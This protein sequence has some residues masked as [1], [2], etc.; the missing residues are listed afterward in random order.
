[1]KCVP[2]RTEARHFYYVS[3]DIG[4]SDGVIVCLSQSNRLKPR[5]M[6]LVTRRH[7]SNYLSDIK[8]MHF[9]AVL[10]IAVL[11]LIVTSAEDRP[12]STPLQFSNECP[13][14]L[15]VF[16]C[17]PI[18]NTTTAANITIDLKALDEIINEP[19]KSQYLNPAAPFAHV[20]VGDIRYVGVSGDSVSAG[21]FA[22]DTF[23]TVFQ[24]FRHYEH[25]E[26][27]WTTGTEEGMISLYNVFQRL[28][29]HQVQ[30]G[31]EKS[32]FRFFDKVDKKVGL[33]VAASKA[34]SEAL[35]DQLGRY[36]ES[37]SL[38]GKTEWL[39]KWKMLNIFVGANDMCR[40]CDLEG[41]E[42]NITR[43]ADG[44]E[45]NIRTA[46]ETLRGRVR[47][48]IVVNLIAYFD[49]ST[50]VENIKNSRRCSA[51][52]KLENLCRCMF[53]PKEVHE[54]HFHLMH[55]E[56]ASRLKKIAMEYQMEYLKQLRG[57]NGQEPEKDSF[58]VYYQ[59]VVQDLHLGHFKGTIQSTV[60]CFHP[61]RC[62]QELMAYVTYNSF[63][64]STEKLKR[65]MVSFALSRLTKTS[66]KSLL[67]K[68]KALFKPFKR[69]KVHQ[70]TS[71]I[72]SSNEHAWICP[73]AETFIQ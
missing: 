41:V 55:N 32:T 52:Q 27:S 21:L 48:R 3:D 11:L 49:I 29:H 39:D 37:L 57:R 9:L 7:S 34:N 43:L 24:P 12:Q 10:S 72:V 18:W 68:V 8:W 31:S 1:M 19:T 67:Q 36:S 40:Y 44:Y 53:D 59:P 15:P 5:G 4:W 46:L 6:S 17:S 26:F 71:I 66:K 28:N 23:L 47:D 13:F 25:R 56:L 38:Y 45:S 51:L 61:N 63:M 16:N 30:G 64:L 33:N 70:P 58:L 73:T 22:E 60:D 69:D 35:N 54:R 50:G 62:G 2:E 65:D 14:A 20:R 42:S